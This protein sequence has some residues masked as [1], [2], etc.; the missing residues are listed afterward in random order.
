MTLKNVGENRSD[1]QERT[2]QRHI[3]HMTQETERR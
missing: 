3:Q 1:N 2:I